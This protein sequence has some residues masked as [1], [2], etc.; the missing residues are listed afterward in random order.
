[1]MGA[2]GMH[3]LISYC[4]LLNK[5][6]HNDK[7]PSSQFRNKVIQDFLHHKPSMFKVISQSFS[8]VMG[9]WWSSTASGTGTKLVV[10]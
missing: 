5:I 7:I 6:T 1:M 3:Y 4:I 2:F 10:D 9:T 8:V